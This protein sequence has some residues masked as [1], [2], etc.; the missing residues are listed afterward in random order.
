ME[1]DKDEILQNYASYFKRWGKT[2]PIE[3]QLKTIRE[4]GQFPQVSVLVDSMFLAELK[5][6]ILTSGH[7]TDAIQGDLLFDV[8]DGGEGYVKING[9][10]Q[11]L[12][13]D[14]VIL[15][16]NNDIL[17]SVLYGPAMK[18]SINPNTRN[19]LYLAWC[20]YGMPEV[21]IKEHLNN[22]L[23][24]LELVFDSP[25]SAVQIHQ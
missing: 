7:D 6:R 16:D 20:P 17:A 1:S 23:S 10:E 22:I 19:P 14:D 8:S 2:Y 5:S 25:F 12:K 21:R 24:N 4:G 13:A 3:F 9:K 15:R 11:T 18:T